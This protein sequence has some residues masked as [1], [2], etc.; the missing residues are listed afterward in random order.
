MSRVIPVDRKGTDCFKWDLQDTEFADVS[1]KSAAK[2]AIP[3]WIADMDFKAPQEVE[4]ALLAVVRHGAYGYTGRTDS[5]FESIRQWLFKR[6]GWDVERAWLDFSPGV[7]PGI[8]ACVNAFTQPGDKIVIQP[9]VYY[10]FFNIVRNNGRQL[11]ENRLVLNGTRFE[12]DFED[13]EEKA[14]DPQVKMMILCSPHNPV[15]RV[16][17]YEELQKLSEICIKHHVLVVSDE[18]H[19]DLILADTPHT[20]LGRIDSD[21]LQQCAAFYAP[22]KTFNLAGL[23]TSACLIAN[24]QMRTAYRAALRKNQTY[25]A[26][27]FGIEAFKAAY[28][29]GGPYLEELLSIL[30]GNYQYVKKYLEEK[31]PEITLFPL[32]GT[33]LAWMDFRK[34]GLPLENLNVFFIKDAKI[35]FDYG[36]IFG[37][38]YGGF[39]R[40]NIA[41]PRD[42]IQTALE[43]LYHAIKK[44]RTDLNK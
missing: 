44:A 12:M 30:R 17:T 26:T 9:P 21:M 3:M 33:Y 43:Q 38:G 41:C 2:E 23:H 42:T 40:M 18:I 15:G 25:S 36:D 8:C 37:A 27:R 24:E 10:P 22:S 19:S 1:M 7:L 31:L 28:Q 39:A 14:A 13:L 5:F 35:M 11:A 20:P 6:H 16:W 4:D 34:C 32:E 29:Y